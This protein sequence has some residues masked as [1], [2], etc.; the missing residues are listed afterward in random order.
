MDNIL[1]RKDG[2]YIS[3][4]NDNLKQSTL[5]KIENPLWY[6]YNHQLVLDEQINFGDI[7]TNLEPY[8]EKLEEHFLAETRGWN[9]RLWFDEIKKEK[10]KQDIQFFEIRF[11]WIFDAHEY[12][13]NKTSKY[14]NSLSKYLSFSAMAKSQENEE[15]HYSTSFMA[16]QNLRDLPV[17]FRKEC[18]ITLW[19]KDTKKLD[20]LFKFEESVTLREL[21]ACLFHEFT[22]FG[23]PE[24]T[25]KQKELLNHNIE[26]LETIDKNDTSKFITSTE[27]QL[28][29]LEKELEQALAEENFE[30]AENV[31]KEIQLI[32]EEGD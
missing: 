24:D 4:Y 23:D 31:R 1:L 9:I 2:F 14:E 12:F 15:D 28:G 11:S 16:I 6:Y 25:K 19:N 7:F 17:T 22:F 30:W 5:V 29:W 3:E 27:L 20:S 21:I 32:K 8:L 10:T 26:E 13:N 18:E